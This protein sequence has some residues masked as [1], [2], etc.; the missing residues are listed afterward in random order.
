MTYEEL[1][2]CYHGRKKT[3]YEQ[4]TQSLREEPVTKRDAVIKAFVKAEKVQV[5]PAKPDPAPRIIQPRQ[6]RFNAE[7]GTYV[8]H[9]E[10]PIYAAIARVFGNTTVAKGM[11]ADQVG[12]LLQQKF[13][14]FKNP[15]AVGLDASR[16]DQ[17]VRRF[18]L[19][20][21]HSVYLNMYVGPDKR[22]LAWLLK[23]QLRNVCRAFLPDG[24]IKYKTDGCRMSGDMNTALG[25]CLLMCAMVWTH[26]RERG[27]AIEL[28]N[29]GDDCVVLME[30]ENLERYTDG[31]EEWFT[32]MGF[33]MKVERPVYTLEKIEFCKT[34]PVLIDGVA[35]MVRAVPVS[36][37]KDLN[38]L[39][40]INDILAL[41]NWAKD[42]GYCGLALTSGIPVVQEFY[43]TLARWGQGA[44]GFNNSIL[45]DS[46][47]FF[48]SIG[49]ES[50]YIQVS[51]STR[52][53]FY[54]AFDISP[55][56]QVSLEKEYSILECAQFT[57]QRYPAATDYGHR[58]RDVTCSQ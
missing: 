26:A 20:W 27:V 55:D 10:K 37:D 43:Q 33:T 42:I 32:Q 51:D 24:K 28:I 21:E 44:K 14:K 9:I 19:R 56:V 13:S 4:A 54:L 57:H 45:V 48:L 25:N 46:G 1:V 47:M 36:I 22:K 58:W 16:F 17:H 40:P 29:N 53:S 35:R 12:V 41:K 52:Y 38:S 15:V 34:Q 8:K 31:L 23:Q 6:P 3:I 50:K 11:N 2:A 7:L 39:L 30:S 5:T 49:M 18:A